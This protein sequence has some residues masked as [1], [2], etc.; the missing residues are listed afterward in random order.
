MTGTVVEDVGKVSLT[1]SS[2]FYLGFNFRGVLPKTRGP[3]PPPSPSPPPPPPFH[4]LPAPPLP[5]EV[6]PLKTS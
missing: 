3:F 4:P 6:G 1:I 5:L 2:G